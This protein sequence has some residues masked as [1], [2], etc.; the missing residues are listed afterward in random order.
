MIKIEISINVVTG[1][2]T[3][4]TICKV[5]MTSNL[6]KWFLVTHKFNKEH[7]YWNHIENYWERTNSPISNN[8]A[9][10]RRSLF[11]VC[12]IRRTFY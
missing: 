5:P 2:K 10:L 3:T 9:L 1:D 4:H 8:K 6:N 7:I 11:V 12:G